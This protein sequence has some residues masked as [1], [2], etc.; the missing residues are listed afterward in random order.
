MAIFVRLWITHGVIHR[1]KTGLDKRPLGVQALHDRWA[2]THRPAAD[3]TR[4]GS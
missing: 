4:R 3:R 1:R 2:F